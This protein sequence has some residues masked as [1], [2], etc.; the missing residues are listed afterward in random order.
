M[1]PRVP[2]RTRVP[3]V[4][5]GYPNVSTPRSTPC[6]PICTPCEPIPPHASTQSTPCAHPCLRNNASSVH[7]AATT[8]TAAAAAQRS[9]SG[10]RRQP[11]CGRC[12]AQHVERSPPR[13]AHARPPHAVDRSVYIQRATGAIERSRK[14]HGGT[15]PMASPIKRCTVE[16]K[17]GDSGHRCLDCS[18]D[19]SSMICMGEVPAVTLPPRTDRFPKWRTPERASFASRRA[20][21]R[22][23]WAAPA[24]ATRGS[25]TSAA[26]SK[27]R[28]RTRLT[29][30][31][32]DGGSVAR[33]SRT[34]RER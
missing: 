32:K 11:R 28:N 31:T 27:L 19:A 13:R 17:T 24:G 6:V 26:S 8:N 4:Y 5:Q 9:G 20:R 10:R 30:A 34:L 12:A 33:A 2:T 25:R 16:F 3:H 18:A 1:C 22:S 15:S 23:R 14:S 7:V 29:E 21:L